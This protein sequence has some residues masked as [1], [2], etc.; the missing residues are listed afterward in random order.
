METKRGKNCRV[1]DAVLIVGENTTEK[2]RSHYIH[3]CNKCKNTSE[4]KRQKLK[5]ETSE[6]WRLNVRRRTA[7]S[8]AKIRKEHPRRSKAQ[9]LYNSARKRATKKNLEFNISSKYL[10]SIMPNECPIMKVT[11]LYERYDK[12]KYTASLDRIDS[13]KGYVKGNVQIISY[14]ANL[15]KSNAT[16][17]ELIAFS[18]YYK[19]K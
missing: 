19:K 4:S 5:N 17:E 12:H 9:L 11:L 8:K 6:E 7:K 3:L 13:D 18:D 10:E 16:K 14:I 15:M 1:C 2:R